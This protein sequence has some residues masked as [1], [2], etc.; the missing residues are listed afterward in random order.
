ML[1]Q[2]VVWFGSTTGCPQEVKKFIL[3]ECLDKP[4]LVFSN[5]PLP[6]ELTAS[7]RQMVEL[8]SSRN[9]AHAWETDR[10]KKMLALHQRCVDEF[11]AAA[12][13]SRAKHKEK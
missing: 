5:F 2:R 3:P 7:L 11:N 6:P 13:A 9:T 12:A 1:P 8:V 4:F 10:I